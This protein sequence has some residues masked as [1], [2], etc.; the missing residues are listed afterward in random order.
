MLKYLY[1]PKN[2]NPIDYLDQAASEKC[3]QIIHGESEIINNL[4]KDK[5]SPAVVYIP[6]IR[7]LLIEN[8]SYQYGEEV[9]FIFTDEWVREEGY[10][11]ASAEIM[12]VDIEDPSQVDLI[13]ELKMSFDGDF[14]FYH[15]FTPK[16][17]GEYII[18]IYAEYEDGKRFKK[19]SNSFIVY[20]D[21]GLGVPKNE[22]FFSFEL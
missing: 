1:V 6:K 22:K 21:N 8:P 3:L 7:T 19:M 14:S 18:Q 5:D 15:K 11:L 17:Y 16:D 2:E 12:H 9:K 10:S 4:V 20:K 13:E